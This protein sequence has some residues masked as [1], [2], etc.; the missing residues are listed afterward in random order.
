MYFFLLILVVVHMLEIH[1]WPVVG[2]L[3]N[4]FLMLLCSVALLLYVCCYVQTNTWWSIKVNH[5]QE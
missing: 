4:C 2:S 1:A 5:Y 3:V